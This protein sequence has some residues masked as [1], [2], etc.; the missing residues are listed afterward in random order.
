MRTVRLVLAVIAFG[1]ALWLVPATFGGGTSY[2][3]THGISMEPRF[4]TGDL[5]IV[6]SADEY[7]VG[8]V[9]AYHSEQLGTVVMHRIASIDNGRYTFKGDNNNFLDPDK[10]TA[11]QLIG[12]LA[13]RVPQG[14][15]WLERVTSP[16]AL[17]LI[18]FGL[19]ATGGSSARTRRRR[20]RG[21]MS[22]HAARPT[23]STPSISEL[24]PQLRTTAGVT[25]MVG[26]LGLALAALA[27]T[28]PVDTASTAKTASSR[29]MVF[30]YDATVGDTPAY[31][32]TTVTS[33]DPVFRKL[34]DTVVA[35]FTYTGEPGTVT[36]AALLST[37]GGWHSTV[38]LAAPE[39]I[40]GRTYTGAVRLD[41]KA[42]AARAQAA[43]AITGVEASPV[44][45]AVTTTVKTDS[46]QAF[47]PALNLSL[48]PLQ[49]MLTGDAK[50]L[51]V[52]DSTAESRATVVPRTLSLLGRRLDVATARIVSA[53]ALLGFLLAAVSLLLLAWRTGPTDEAAA[54]R[55]RYAQLLV[56]VQ[57]M[58]A[59]AGRPVVDVRGF[60]TLVRLA[61]RY[62]L[63][64]LHWSRSGVETFLV[65][66]EGTTFRY[67]T[68]SSGHGASDAD[69]GLA[70]SEPQTRPELPAG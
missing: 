42:F 44:S 68:G 67:R 22:R 37:S 33:P 70:S 21:T 6:R 43:A 29:Q 48:T 41:L 45:I 58:S 3:A 59:P 32:T 2:V 66:D 17:G 16:T 34:T 47:T 38:P 63:L 57:P 4:H 12:K 19:L 40:R 13:I 14:A 26:V 60:A 27:W 61:E 35:H 7:R 52:S 39:R 23:R 25:A 15:V 36:V 9:T 10:P 8:D 11:T 65:Q 20:R 51:T 55:R 49:L 54:I 62:G 5:A 69:G 18:A 56:P 53:V 64:I 1:G 31:D 50:A 28:G 30:S 46:G 24:P